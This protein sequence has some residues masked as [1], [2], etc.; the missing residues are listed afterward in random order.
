MSWQSL[1][2]LN[3]SKFKLFNGSF[4]ELNLIIAGIHCH[5]SP[6]GHIMSPLT[7][8]RAGGRATGASTTSSHFV[9]VFIIPLATP[10]TTGVSASLMQPSAHLSYP[11]LSHYSTIIGFLSTM[12]IVH[13]IA[14]PPTPQGQ[15]LK[16]L[17][18]SLMFRFLKPSCT[19]FGCQPGSLGLGYINTIVI[20]IF[21]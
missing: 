8:M 7:N 3:C 4:L 10:A 9:L 14:N 21:V 15:G 1:E 16:Q 6:L 5:M 11:L 13:C 2:K 12:Y 17:S 20:S 18:L 19:S